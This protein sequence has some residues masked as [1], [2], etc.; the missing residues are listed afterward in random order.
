MKRK[1]V[2]ASRN[3]DKVRE[4][5]QLFKGLDLE[6]LSAADF[7][8][9]PEV[10]EDGTSI[11]GNARRKAVVTAA[12]TGEIAVADDTSLEV[13]ELNGF[14]DIFAARFSGPEATYES[15]VKLLL[16][17]MADVKAGRRQARF[18]TACVWVDPRP[19]RDD[20]EAARP[21]QGRWLRNPWERSIGIR[22]TDT[23]WDF[24][25]ELVD[26]RKA[27]AVYRRRM[28]LD[29]VSWGHDRSRLM[30]ISAELFRGC[31]DAL[32][33]GEAFDESQKQE[34][35][36]LPDTRIWAIDGPGSTTEPITLVAPSGMP[37]DAPGR[38]T[39]APVW[40]E[41][42]TEG[43]ILGD[44]TTE[45]IGSRGFGY[46]PIFRPEG[47]RRTLAEMPAHEKN[48]VSHR[49][50]AMRRLLTAVREAYGT[51]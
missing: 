44:I 50:H 11:V 6:I 18:S 25:N 5:Q 10:I 32:R 40:F 19:E 12:Y 39:N 29:Q 27:W 31:S 30:A 38:E 26:R 9:L 2:L 3:K 48:A 45:P 34:G 21:A 42:A 7:P 14:P 16:E 28:E 35:I 37:A 47:E 15:N 22:D 20:L 49:G 23:E 41:M 8:G 24:W 51:A 17:L 1:V 36:R 4:L 13:R 33:P 46:D 43:K